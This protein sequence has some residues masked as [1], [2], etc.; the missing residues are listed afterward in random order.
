MAATLTSEQID[1]FKLELG[2]DCGKLTDE[3]YQ[4]AYDTADG[5]DCG[6]LA[7]LYRWLL[8]KVKPTKIVLATGGEAFSRATTEYYESRMAYWQGC[9]G[10][11][12]GVV[13][14]MTTT[15]TTPTRSDLPSYDEDGTAWL[16]GE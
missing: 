13:V 14:S 4:L 10:S 6:T 3:Q 9:A 7:V 16:W 11:I 5:N 1:Y 15:V 2:D 8:A 12:N